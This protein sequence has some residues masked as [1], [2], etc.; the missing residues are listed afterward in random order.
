MLPRNDPDR[1]QVAFDGPPPGTGRAGGSHQDPAETLL[2]PPRTAH[3]QGTLPH[4]APAPGLALAKP[5]QL[6]PGEIARPATTLLITQ[7]CLTRPLEYLTNQH[8]AVPACLP[9]QSV[10]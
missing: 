8:Q 2:L 1:I 3:P 10:H 9:P 4:P 5:I 7:R 6:R